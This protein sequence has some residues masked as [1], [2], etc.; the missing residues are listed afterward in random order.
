MRESARQQIRK[1][2]VAY[3]FQ[4]GDLVAIKRTQYGVG[5][6]LAPKYFGPYR[7]TQVKRGDR[8]QVDRVVG[9]DGPQRTHTSADYMKAWPT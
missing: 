1:R 9:G 7:V 8:Y 4:V 3:P 2:K 6:K 5:L